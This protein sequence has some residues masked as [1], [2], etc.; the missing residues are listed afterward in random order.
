MR[1]IRD[2]VFSIATAGV[3]TVAL[4]VA[5]VAMVYDILR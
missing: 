3:L 2:W 1:I 4:V 5:L